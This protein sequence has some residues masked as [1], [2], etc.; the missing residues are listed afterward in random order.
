LNV[1]TLTGE[2]T[3][4]FQRA[5]AEEPAWFVWLPSFEEEEMTTELSGARDSEQNNSIA[6]ARHCVANGHIIRTCDEEFGIETDETR[7]PF[8]QLALSEQGYVTSAP[9]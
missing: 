5:V 7:A 1:H 9:S 8:F 3:A 4:L 2:S 6:M